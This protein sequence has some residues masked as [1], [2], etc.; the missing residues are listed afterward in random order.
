MSAVV[1]CMPRASV[2][3]SN[4]EQGP[5]ACDIQWAVKGTKYIRCPGEIPTASLHDI[6]I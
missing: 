5:P 3:I 1:C 2:I 6:R 4:Q